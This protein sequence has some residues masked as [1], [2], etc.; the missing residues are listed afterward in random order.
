[1]LFRSENPFSTNRTIELMDCKHNERR[2]LC[3]RFFLMPRSTL[4][5]YYYFLNQEM[6]EDHFTVLQPKEQRSF[7]YLLV[8]VRTKIRLVGILFNIK[9]SRQLY[10]KITFLFDVQLFICVIS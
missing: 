7:F 3:E 8:D 1:V 9:E 2:S 6:A 4:L 10:R 5:S